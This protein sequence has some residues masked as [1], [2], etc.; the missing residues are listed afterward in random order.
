MCKIEAFFIWCIGITT[1]D[2]LIIADPESIISSFTL[3]FMISTES[4]VEM[5]RR[6]TALLKDPESSES[7][8]FEQFT[9]SCIHA[10]ENNPFKALADRNGWIVAPQPLKKVVD[11]KGDSKLRQTQEDKPS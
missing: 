10:I 6:I 4:T 1:A 11:S 8:E 5:M 7:N 3:A 9:E 2:H